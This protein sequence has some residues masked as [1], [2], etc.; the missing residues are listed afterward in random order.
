MYISIIN[1]TK[2][3]YH[4]EWLYK[5]CATLNV[6][7]GGVNAQELGSKIR[8]NIYILLKLLRCCQGMVV[9]EDKCPCSFIFQVRLREN[10]FLKNASK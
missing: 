9:V 4:E 1:N 6:H 8:K 5:G 10:V 3:A 7:I 2:R